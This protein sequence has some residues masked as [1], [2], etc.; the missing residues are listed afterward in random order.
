M[1]P[2]I[3]ADAPLPPTLPSSLSADD[4]L[5]MESMLEVVNP[6]FDGAGDAA[7]PAPQGALTADRDDDALSRDGGSFVS[8]TPRDDVILHND[9]LQQADAA[10]DSQGE[11]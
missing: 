1:S 10:A 8:G 2:P 11:G 7:A 6:A 4:S 3:V 5:V 9:G